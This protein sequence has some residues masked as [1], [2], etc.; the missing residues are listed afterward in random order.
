M[1]SSPRCQLVHLASRHAVPATYALRDYVEVGGLMS[2]GPNIVDAF[3][4]AGVY[5]GRILKGA[6]PADLPVRAPGDR[7]RYPY[8][9]RNYCAH[10]VMVMRLDPPK[11]LS[12]YVQLR[13]FRGCFH[14][15]FEY[16]RRTPPS[17]CNGLAHL[18]VH[19]RATSVGNRTLR[20]DRRRLVPYIALTASRS[21]CV[22]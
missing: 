3:R 13:G 16:R 5:T 6:K 11:G 4:Q 2:Y 10:P 9:L 15:H 22:F 14:V 17:C 18:R 1:V 7:S 8:R 21:S 12:I 19:L 20:R